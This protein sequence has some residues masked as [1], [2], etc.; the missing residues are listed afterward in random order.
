MNHPKLK[1]TLLQAFKS[2]GTLVRQSIT[3][4]KTI[5]KKGEIDLV[6][7]I[8]CAAEKLIIKIISKAFPDHS[9]LC[10]ES[11]TTRH[12]G[13]AGQS[14]HRWIIDPIDGTTNFAHSLP[15]CSVSIAYEENGVVR[16]G[17]VYDPM[18]EELFYAEKGKGAFLNGKKIRVSKTKQLNDALLST[19]F[20]YDRRKD[21]DKYLK[22]FREFLMQAQEIRR[23]GSA[24]LDLCYVACGRFDGYWEAKLSPWDK[25]AGMLI[26][27][28]AGGKL[29]NY[30]G[31]PLTLAEPTIVASNGVIHKAILKT[32]NKN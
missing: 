16:M 14:K 7:E 27:K 13:Q 30:A 31:E 17:G 28:E 24:A 5:T 15:I 8:D 6:T 20:P 9:F 18:R 19:G 32:L 1:R 4:Q 23:L 22:I 29:S 2:A 12:G 11:G 10:E 26:L 25:A 3:R 21:P